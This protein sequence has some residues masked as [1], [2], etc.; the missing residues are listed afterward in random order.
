M[1]PK[2]T[3]RPRRRLFQ[4]VLAGMDITKAAISRYVLNI[5]YKTFRLHTASLLQAMRSIGY[6]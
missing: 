4:L 3:F 1:Y 2:H 6:A 5:V